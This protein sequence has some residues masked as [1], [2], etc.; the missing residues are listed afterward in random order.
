MSF[1]Q[2]WLARMYCG[3]LVSMPGGW[4]K[5]TLPLEKTGSGKSVMPCER[6]QATALR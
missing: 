5:L 2:I 1:R 6:M 3:E 4:V